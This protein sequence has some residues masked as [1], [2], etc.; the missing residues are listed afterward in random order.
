MMNE[1]HLQFL[2]HLC[3][4]GAR[5]LIIGG[6]ARYQLFDTPTRDLDIWLDWE[7][8]SRP[9][10]ETALT[11][12]ALRYPSHIWPPLLPRYCLAHVSR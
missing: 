4:A 12:W 1:Y 7:G 3:A 2:L 11:D 6:Q 5:F 10:A 9:P 8:S